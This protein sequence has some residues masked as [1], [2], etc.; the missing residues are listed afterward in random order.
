MNYFWINQILI[1]SKAHLTTSPDY[2][3]FLKFLR[4]GNNLKKDRAL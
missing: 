4:F 1:Y 2:S 3:T